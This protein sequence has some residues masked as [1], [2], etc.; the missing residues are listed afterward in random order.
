VE[1]VAAWKELLR[2]DILFLILQLDVDVNMA[3]ACVP[4]VSGRWSWTNGS[5]LALCGV[6]WC[7]VMFC[8]FLQPCINSWT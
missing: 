1:L 4:E 6:G 3:D 7:G 2:K 5:L 8:R